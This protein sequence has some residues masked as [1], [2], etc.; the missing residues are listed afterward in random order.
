M[1]DQLRSPPTGKPGPTIL[2]LRDATR[3]A[4]Q[5]LNDH[6]LLT[7]LVE[8][9]LSWLTY[10]RILEAFYGFY[11]PMERA[12]L[13]PH[14]DGIRRFGLVRRDRTPLLC[15]DLRALGYGEVAIEAL[16]LCPDLPRVASPIEALGCLYVLDGAALGGKVIARQV[17]KSLGRR[18]SDRLAFFTS[19]GADVATTWRHLMGVIEARTGHPSDRREAVRGA[20][21]TFECLARWIDQARGRAIA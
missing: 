16:E 15:R 10:A 5:S 19:G 8:P 7:Q 4:H 1:A 18:V 14:G 13:G 9:D 3:S 17:R 21:A 6:A 11:A 2:A 20:E 12:R